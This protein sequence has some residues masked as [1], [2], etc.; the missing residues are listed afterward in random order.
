M[1]PGSNLCRGVPPV[2]GG[3]TNIDLEI[4][5]TNLVASHRKIKTRLCYRCAL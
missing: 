3:T 5:S 4:A 2:Q 1:T